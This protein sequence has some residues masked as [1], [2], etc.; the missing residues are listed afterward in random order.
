MGRASSEL[1]DLG[2]ACLSCFQYYGDRERRECPGMASRADL[3]LLA[4]LP[5]APEG[6]EAQKQDPAETREGRRWFVRALIVPACTLQIH[7]P[8]PAWLSPSPGQ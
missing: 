7:F 4:C 8:I 3:S 6:R 2:R 1:P 5:R